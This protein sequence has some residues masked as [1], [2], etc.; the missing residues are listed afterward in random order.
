MTISTDA[1]LRLCETVRMLR[2]LAI[3]LPDPVCLSFLAHGDGPLPEQASPSVRATERAVN[4]AFAR[5]GVHA[6][7][8]LHGGE[9]QLSSFEYF[10]SRKICE[11]LDYRYDHFDDDEESTAFKRALKHFDFSGA[12]PHIE[13]LHLTTRDNVALSVYAGT[14]RERPAIV[15]ALPCGMPFDLCRDW[16]D[17]LSERF[18]VVTWETR[19][20]FGAC[21]S[22]DGIAVD[23][24]A[25]VADLI[26]VM[27][28]YEL[29][30][31]HLMGICGGAVIALS[32]AAAHGDRVSSLSLWHGDYNL[33]DDN[34]RT[35][36]QQ[37]FEWLMEA[38]AQDR[39]EAS[40]LQTMFLDQATLATTPE[41]IAHVALYPYVNPEL[42]YRY[43]RLNDALNK[44]E[45]ASQLA[46]VAVPT[47]V[48]AGDADATTHIG[49]SRHIAASIEEATLHVER[50]GSHLAFFESTQLAKQTAFNFLEEVLQPT[51][52]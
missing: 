49:G 7:Q 46:R 32:A 3:H 28:H 52:A 18:F 39:H 51:F 16:F 6:L 27:N 5:I 19:G 17:A 41:P 48:V 10:I 30:T 34:L 8:Y 29:S 21:E 14:H 24:Q 40:D 11:A 13:A 12:A 35:A 1:T 36:H 2:H 45:L 43:A 20:L 4:A 9:A 47:L 26:S 37:N 15:L 22:F 42:F 31:A 50:D 25:Q 38:A 33:G 23:T 44:T